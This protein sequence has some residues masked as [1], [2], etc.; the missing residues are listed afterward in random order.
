[1]ANNGYDSQDYRLG[2]GKDADDNRKGGYG[3][4]KKHRTRVEKAVAWRKNAKYD[5]KW[6]KFIKLYA[7][8]YEY[9]EL[10]AYED[11]VAP[12]M[13]F[14]TV[15]IIVPSVVVNYP[16]ITV[17]ARQE[18]EAAKAATV[19]AMSNYNWQRYNVHK[20]VKLIIRDSVMF[21]H[22][23]GKVTWVLREETQEMDRDEYKATVSQALMEVTSGRESAE[24]QGLG[25]TF[26]S[27]D[28]VIASAPTTKVVVVADHP[29]V[30]RISPFDLYMDPDATRFENARWIAQRMY[31]PI[32]TAR[33]NQDWNKAARKKLKPSAMSEAKSDQE[34]TFD[35][36][37]RG[38]E[39]EFV[40]VWEYYDLLANTMCVFA[41][42]C[43]EFLIEPDETPL[44]FSHPFVFAPN[45]VVPE[46]LYPL[47]DVESLV[48]LQMELALTRTQMINDR[49]RFRRMYLYS[50]DKIGADG[51]TA[52]LSGDDNAMIPVEYDGP[53]SDVLAPVG[54]SALPPEFYNQTAMIMEDI[55]LQAGTN[56]Y[57]RGG[58]TEIRRTAT[59]A[60][61]IQEASNARAADKLA[62]VE[63]FISELARR[64]VQLAQEFLTTE[65]VARVMGQDG[66]I[67]WTPY[68]REDI[69]G[70]F[71]F[72]VEAGSTRPLNESQKRQS[73]MQLM[74]AMAPFI[75]MGV[76]NPQKIAETVLRDGFG[77]KNPEMYM[78]QMPPMMPPDQGGVPVG[79]PPMPPGMPPGMPP[80][81]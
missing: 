42:G 70:E 68:S 75:S 79:G 63:I 7:S 36:E 30:E 50:Q 45:Y 8:Q 48:S 23:I 56:E 47:G 43:D 11:I 55:N 25:V 32:E 74:D 13:V 12:N 29:S 58:T 1:M 77:I 40:V 52:L 80:M 67:Q 81:M 5:E 6:A 15:N 54:T 3:S 61:M 69:V 57:Q 22:G 31:V 17:T 34:T 18:V 72:Q 16:K 49:K 41:D 24:S 37:E 62:G 14:S 39:S 10:S 71:D 27:D 33:E 2:V 51:M 9:K 28:E 44:P 38:T 65:Q 4:S 21:G 76:V 73:A 20:E 78:A 19:E 59:E 66:A 60:N 35:G 53:L 64:T 26:P 46:K